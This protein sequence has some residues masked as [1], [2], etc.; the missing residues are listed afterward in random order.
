MERDCKM[1]IEKFTPGEWEVVPFTDYGRDSLFITTKAKKPIA[2]V[3]EQITDM[4][5]RYVDWD[6]DTRKANA[7]LLAAAPDM[8]WILKRL[9]ELTDYAELVGVL[10]DAKTTLKRAKGEDE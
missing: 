4:K 8:Y 5:G 10:S 7:H 1:S 9:T 3:S 6:E 2:Y